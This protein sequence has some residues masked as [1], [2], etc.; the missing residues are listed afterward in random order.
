MNLL[1][2]ILMSIIGRGLRFFLISIFVK[3]YGNRI[4]Q[5]L[6]K[7]IF[8]ITTILGVIILI[9]ISLV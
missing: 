9:I 6:Q 8:L 5:L 4:I 7:K 1:S 3:I 2:F